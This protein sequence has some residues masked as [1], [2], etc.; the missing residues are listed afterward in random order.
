MSY[1]FL[2]IF[3]V[4]LVCGAY[5]HFRG[6]VR[7]KLQR[8]ITDHSIFLSPLNCLFFLFSKHPN[9]PYVDVG[10]FKELDVL[11]ENW[12]IIQEEAVKLYDSA[13]IKSSDRLDDVGFQSLFRTGWKRFYLKW[14]GKP[15][16]SANSLCPN[17]VSILE[18]IPNVRGGMFALLPPDGKLSGHRD[19]YAGSLRYHLGLVTPNSA[20]CYI[21][22]DGEKYFWKDGEA[23]IFDETYIH[24][25]ENNT[26]VNRIILFLDIK[27]PVK[28]FFVSWLDK[29]FSHIF[30]S[31]AATKNIDGDKVGLI[32]KIFPAIYST[33]RIGQKVKAYNRKLYYGLKYLV[34]AL[35]FYFLIIHWIVF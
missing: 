24:S 22:V 31:A 4:F 5:I 11:Q 19:P 6:K 34:F 1:I 9:K 12:Q 35:L 18:T 14:Y 8:Q 23:V 13:K 2:T 30:M 16:P 26:D 7:F 32:N 33:A 29:I 17:T 15:L 25:V 28:F 27:R 10:H 3:I 21:K 20:D